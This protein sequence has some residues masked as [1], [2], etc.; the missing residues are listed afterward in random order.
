LIVS[1]IPKYR[2]R[3]PALLRGSLWPIVTER[4]RGMRWT[5]KVSAQA[6]RGRLTL[7]RTAKSCGPDTP[8]L[9]SSRRDD[10]LADDGG[11]KARSP[12]S[13]RR[14]PLKP[15]RREGRTGPNLW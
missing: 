7:S 9:V 10:D 11:K 14:T 13:T 2:P 4:E 5:R 15:L 1:G 6:L 8:T 12:G 3:R